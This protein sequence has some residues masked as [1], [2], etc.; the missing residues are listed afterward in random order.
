MPPVTAGCCNMEFFCLAM[1]MDGKLSL[2][3]PSCN[4][5]G[6]SAGFF[7]PLQILCA[8]QLPC[9]M[10]ITHT[11]SLKNYRVNTR[12]SPSVIYILTYNICI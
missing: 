5:V 4:F 1:K 3:S 7:L 12:N 6:D 11:C 9:I 8:T 10:I 2:K